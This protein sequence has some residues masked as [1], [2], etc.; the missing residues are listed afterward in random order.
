MAEERA[1][2]ADARR[3]REAIVAAAR[4]VFDQHQQ[5]RFDDFAALAG[6][7]VGTL[8]RHF[9]TRDA[10]AA[11]VYE[12]EVALLCENAVDPARPAVEN[13]ES[14]LRGFVEYVLEHTGL[15]RTLAAAEDP[16][17]FTDGGIQI[18][19]TVADLV[20]QAARDGTVRDDMPVGA[21]MI[22]LH[23]IGTATGRPL[24]ASESR[25]AVELLIA[26]LRAT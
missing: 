5:A 13:L 12:G 1:M 25:A 4:V 26:G 19:C 11:A 7:G 15:A 17:V 16:T 24:W 22:V 3:N 21:V 23:G 8:Y 10:L 6:V 2:R 18:E 20:S 9:P 14:F